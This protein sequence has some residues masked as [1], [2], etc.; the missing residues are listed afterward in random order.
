MRPHPPPAPTTA[1]RPP[2]ASD[3]VRVGL[4]LLLALPA[5]IG[6][7]VG[8]V[9]PTIRT[10]VFSFQERS[11]LPAGSSEFAGFDNYADL[12]SRETLEAYGAAALLPLLPVVALLLVGPLLAYAAH[13]AGRATRWTTRLVL[14]VP[15]V[16]FAPT[17][18]AVAWVVERGLGSGQ[19]RA[20]L[21]LGTFGLAAG[22][23]VTLFLA[24]LRGRTPGRSGW[25]AGVAVG[26]VAGIATVAVGLQTF[27]YP[28]LFGAATPV[29]F[30][31]RTGFLQAAAGPAAAH[32]AVLFG[33]LLVLG[34]GAALIMI[35]SGLRLTVES[36]SRPVPGSGS[37]GA[38]V[39]TGAGLLV[40]LA[41][42]GYGLWPWLSRLGEID[43]GAGPSAVSVLVD[44]WLPPLLSSVV[45]VGLAAVAGFGIG[46]LRPLGRWSELLLLPFAPWLFVGTGPLALAR[47]DAARDGLFG[48]RIGTFLGLVP[49][50]WLVIPALFLFTLLF[51]GLSTQE[52]GPGAYGRMV[53]AALPMLAL[54]GAA[55]WLVQSQSLLWSLLV[56]SPDQLTGPVLAFQQGA[57]LLRE[58]TLGLVLPLPAILGF[59]VGLGL[60]QLLYLDRLAIRTGRIGHNPD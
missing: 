13:R 4:G 5:G 44:T 26:A 33:V 49:P 21:W 39:A 48:E 30:I 11:L 12:A 28:V 19:A 50:G 60:L 43:T 45:G 14:A 54:A 16:C 29:S 34:I 25:P 37:V 2:S 40:V 47:F 59:A 20:A 36:A 22:L 7:L 56:S 24:V 8:Q 38:A 1:V 9:L 41:V 18:I 57:R 55:T 23:G 52:G 6:L 58:G 51:R 17:A 46:A 35:L 15:M 42:A 3:P 10:L 27:A 53:V 31:F 32:G